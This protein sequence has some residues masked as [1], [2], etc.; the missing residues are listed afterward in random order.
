MTYEERK[1]LKKQYRKLENTIS[2][3]EKKIATLEKQVAEAHDAMEQ[4]DYS[5]EAQTS[6]RLAAYDKL[7]KELD[8]VMHLW[9]NTM[10]EMETFDTSQLD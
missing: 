1:E 10:A 2:N 4:L 3:C 9:E 5:D 7:K 8:E 6:E